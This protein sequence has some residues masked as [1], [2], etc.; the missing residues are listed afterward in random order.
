MT[1]VSIK[2]KYILDF[3]VWKVKLVQSCNRLRFYRIHIS[4]GKYVKRGLCDIIG[5]PAFIFLTLLILFIFI[6]C[7][8]RIRRSC[9][10]T[11]IPEVRYLCLHRRS[12]SSG[13]HKLLGRFYFPFG[14]DKT[15]AENDLKRTLT[16]LQIWCFS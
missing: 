14:G 13:I 5:K 2:S 12:C 15:T 16:Y 4:L 8:W 9:S 1:L 3:F 7:S 6:S 11:F 10:L